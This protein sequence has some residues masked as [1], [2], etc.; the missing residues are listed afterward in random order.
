MGWSGRAPPLPAEGT[1]GARSQS[2]DAHPRIPPRHVD[3]L[4]LLRVRVTGRRLAAGQDPNLAQ[5]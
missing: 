4:I 2:H 5:A 3:E 1:I